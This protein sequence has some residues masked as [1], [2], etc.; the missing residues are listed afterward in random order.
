MTTIKK[1]SLTAERT[2]EVIEGAVRSGRITTLFKSLGMT[3]IRLVTDQGEWELPD[4]D[5]LF[6]L[7]NTR[8]SD[9][10]FGAEMV[11][12]REPATAEAD[13]S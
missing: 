9:P 10:V 6:L 4:G 5:F 13:A 2:Q 7:M 12:S 3:G 1:S 11:G 8:A